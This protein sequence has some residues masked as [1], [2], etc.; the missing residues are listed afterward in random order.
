M[1]ALAQRKLLFLDADRVFDLA[2]VEDFAHEFR[3]VFRQKGYGLVLVPAAVYELHII[4]T[5]G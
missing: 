3:E 1:V 5:H 2:R 4:S